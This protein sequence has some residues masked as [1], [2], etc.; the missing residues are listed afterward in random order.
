MTLLRHA[1][2]LVVREPRRSVVAIIGVAIASGL[3]TGVLL[4]GTASASTVTRRALADLPVDAQV[5]L[6]PTADAAGARA[7]VEADTAAL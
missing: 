3:V 5:I 1:L 2:R 7:I 6:G 4:F